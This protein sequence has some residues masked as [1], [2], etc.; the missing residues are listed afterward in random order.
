M[1]LGVLNG[2]LAYRKVV[3]LR[4][5]PDRWRSWWPAFAAGVDIAGMD[6]PVPP[7]KEDDPLLDRDWAGWV[8]PDLTPVLAVV[9]S[10]RAARSGQP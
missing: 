8:R 6:N 5:L 10:W 2:P 3:A 9:L 4:E 1:P 7:V